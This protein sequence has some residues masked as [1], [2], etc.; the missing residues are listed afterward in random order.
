VL[1][2]FGTVSVRVM[3]ACAAQGVPLVAHFHGYDASKHSTLAEYGDG[4][5]RLFNVAAVLV[6]VSRD[7]AKQLEALG[8]P[9]GK[10]EYNPCSVDL[11][12]FYGAA[13]EQ[14]PPKFLAMGRYVDK[15]AP[16]LTL[17]AF[18]RVLAA[19]PEA[20]LVMV[21]DG[22][23]RCA[24]EDLAQ[25]MGISEAVQFV[26]FLPNLAIASL[27]RTMRGFVQHSVTARD[28]NTEGT[29][30]A[31]MEAA[32]SGLPIVSTRHA[33]IKN[34]VRHGQ[35]GYL[36]EPGDIAAMASHWTELARDPE[37]A[38]WLGR[39]GRAFIADSPFERSRSIARLWEII[40]K[41][42]SDATARDRPKRHSLHQ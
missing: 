24:C 2:E 39:N 13:P 12:T 33:G 19:C 42:I 26:S 34:V 1:A 20:R 9:P 16:H 17:L 18:S 21:G 35:T 6:V 15:K 5:R 7:M 22:P 10:I 31:I 28:G 14:A 41:A 8:A 36:V 38:Q 3:E 32:A 23:L 27:M 37:L 30:V 4:Y 40:E 25:A 11:E 29:P